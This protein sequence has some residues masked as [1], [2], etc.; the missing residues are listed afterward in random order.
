MK[1]FAS[2]HQ[3][4]SEEMLLLLGSIIT[5]LLLELF[6][7]V[8]CGTSFAVDVLFV[9]KSI[10]ATLGHF[11]LWSFQSARLTGMASEFGGCIFIKDNDT[12]FSCT[13]LLHPKY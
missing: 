9:S 12:A 3:Y 5:L 13:L 7:F 6:K 4:F 2:I 10:S 1:Y 11:P 8:S